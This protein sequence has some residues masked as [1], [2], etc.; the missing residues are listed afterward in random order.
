MNTILSFSQPP[1][2]LKLLAHDIRWKILVLLGRSDY[3]VQEIV[4]LLEQ[5]QNLV[6]YH[7]RRLH[8]Q[9]LVTERR[10]TADGR[11]IYYSL[12]INMLRTLYF[13]A[14]DSLNPVLNT[15]DV[16]SALQEAVSHLPSKKVRVLFLCTHNSARS[17][18]A[19]GILRHL[20]GGRI[21]AYSAGSQPTSLHPLA[22]QTMAKM[23]IDISQQRSKHLDEYLDQSF[24]YIVTVCDR[25]RESCPTFP[26]DPERV[27][28]SFIDPA[29]VE[30]S[31]K[32]R[33]KAFEQVALQ[34]TNRI[35]Y[36]VIL[37]EREKSGKV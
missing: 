18:I 33:Y 16:D 37:I 7:L 32:D 26:G 14:A 35:R 15:T 36:L 21:E 34:L 29:A 25:V 12:D 6:S 10:S 8:D 30:G 5:P 19:E 11:D 1:S 3:C 9:N 31:E 28:W 23:G 24:D 17:Q 27:H 2:F 13:A 4:R 20:S 22:I